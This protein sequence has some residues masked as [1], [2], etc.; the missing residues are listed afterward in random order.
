MTPLKVYHY[1]FNASEDEVNQDSFVAAA[2]ICDEVIGEIRSDSNEV[3][4]VEG[5]TRYTFNGVIDGGITPKK[6]LKEILR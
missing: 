4:L 5:Y 6:I 3:I 1:G 2:N